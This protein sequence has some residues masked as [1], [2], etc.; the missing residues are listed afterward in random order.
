MHPPDRLPPPPDDLDR[1]LSAFF[2]AEV[3]D[4][5]PAAPAV[6]SAAPSRRPRRGSRLALAAAVALLLGGQLYLA[7][8]FLDTPTSGP[9]NPG[10]LTGSR[11]RPKPALTTPRDRARAADEDDLLPEGKALRR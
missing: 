10:R 5:W 11:S 7:G 8:R 3:P 9:D 1:L 6:P 4:P 2:R